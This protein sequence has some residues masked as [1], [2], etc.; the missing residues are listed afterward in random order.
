MSTIGFIGAGNMG[1]SIISG[2]VI[3][4]GVNAED[5]YV[6]DPRVADDI[7]ALGVNVCELEDT[8]RKSDYIVLAVKPNIMGDVLDKISKITQTDD[9]VF[10]TIA[11]G[12]DIAY[13][14]LG[15]G[16]KKK[17]VRV[18][19]NL[20]MS[21]GEGMSVIC[22]SDE[23]E[24]NEL[25]AAVKIFSC[26]GKTAVSANEDMIDKCIAIN[27][28]APAYVFMFIEAL[29]DGAVKNGVPRKDAYELAAQTVLGSAK[30]V[31]DSGKHPGVLK[32]M[33]CSPGG[34][35]IEAVCSLEADGFRNAVINAV[36]ACTKKAEAMKTD[37]SKK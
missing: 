1:G 20:P 24:E 31:L 37:I 32:D 27:G 12:I 34:T 13:M 16:K 9:K 15:I 29:A 36:E 28:S 21:V 2:M 19:P 30:M 6:T 10:I 8:V 17:I 11:A 35:T 7:K 4:G 33:V 18:M 25:A 3:R 26:V 5:V 23:V 14:K 22:S